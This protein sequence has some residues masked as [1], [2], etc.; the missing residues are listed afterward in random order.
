MEYLR[1]L[2]ARAEYLKMRHPSLIPDG[3]YNED[4]DQ[5]MNSERASMTIQ[6]LEGIVSRANAELA[7]RWR[8]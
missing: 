5:F 4:W 8:K 1:H 6:Y 7:K 2:S 3:V